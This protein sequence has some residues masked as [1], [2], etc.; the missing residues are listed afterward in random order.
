MLDSLTVRIL[1]QYTHLIHCYVLFSVLD[2]YTYT[3]CLSRDKF[4]HRRMSSQYNEEE[5]E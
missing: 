5:L 2:I 4:H 3:H 1:A